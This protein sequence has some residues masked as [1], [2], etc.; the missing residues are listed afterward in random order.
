MKNVLL[1]GGGGFGIIGVLIVIGL[2]VIGW[3]LIGV[4]IVDEGC[5]EVGVEFVFGK[6]IDQIGIGFYYNWFYF[7]G[8]VYKL[9]VEQ[10]CEMIVG[11]EELFII[12]G[13]V[14]LCDVLEESLMLIGDENIVD[15]GFKVQWCIKNICEGIINYLFN[16][17]NL[18]GIVKVVVESVMCEVVGEFNIDVILIQNWV[19]I[20]ND[21]GM[22]M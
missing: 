5:G 16:I 9:Q 11:V 15:V 2:G 4:Y 7:I 14:C 10:Q 19:N 8:E 12:L 17:Q 1:G 20:Q 21:V 3:F 22:L 6:V 18:E 13:N